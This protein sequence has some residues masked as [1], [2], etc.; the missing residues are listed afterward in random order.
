MERK[1]MSLGKSSLVISL[2]KEWMQLNNLEKGD[3]VSFNIQRDRSL[4]VHP[5]LKKSEP[6]EITLSVGQNEEDLLISQKILGAFLNGYSGIILTS[7]KIFSVSQTKTIRRM[8]GR[9]YMRVMEADSKCVY[10]QSLMDESK[11]S[12]EQAIQRM[13]LISSSMVEGAINS[14]QSGDIELAKSV[15]TLDEDVDHFAFFILRI[16]RNAAQD[17]ALA[18]ELHVD[19]LDCMDHQIL[20]Y[21]MEYAADYAADIAKHIIMLNGAKQKIPTDVLQIMITTGKEVLDLYTK[22][23][24]AFFSKD[25]IGAVEIM[26]YRQKMDKAEV[27]IATK[28]FT[29][30][31]KSADLVCGICS[32]RDDIKRICHC[33]F[34]MAEMTVNRAFKVANPDSSRLNEE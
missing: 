4:V 33:A 9:L 31:P 22:G 6:K 14:L 34:A 21:R 2:P 12:L 24:G 5:A 26:K 27:E 13:H 30:Q 1:I 20:V 18:N 28:S 25:V 19:P 8:A 7:D 16:L 32:T 15:M 23:I 10:I 11:A 17:P 29:G 3:S